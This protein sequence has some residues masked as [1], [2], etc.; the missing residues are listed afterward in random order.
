MAPILPTVTP[1]V[2]IKKV[3]FDELNEAQQQLIK[4]AQERPNQALKADTVKQ[5]ERYFKDKSYSPEELRILFQS[6][7]D[8]GWGIVMGEGNRLAFGWYDN[9]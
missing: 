6:T 7:A 2:N 8:V 3:K 9:L 5:Y 4:F 1:E